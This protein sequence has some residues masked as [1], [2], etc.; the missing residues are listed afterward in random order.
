MPVRWMTESPARTTRL[1]MSISIS[2]SLITGMNGRSG[3][4]RS[5]LTLERSL[6]IKCPML[7]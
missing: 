1:K 3:S 4:P 2:P 7:H 6:P 5:R